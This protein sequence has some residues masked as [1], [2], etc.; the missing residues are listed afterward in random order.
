[1]TKYDVQVKAGPLLLLSLAALV[2]A[3]LFAPAASAAPV[4]TQLTL[5]GP[6]KAPGGT[7]TLTAK[8]AAN[9]QPLGGKTVALFAGQ[10]SP[11]VSGAT[12]AAG[13]IA[14]EVT[15]AASTQFQ[16]SYDPAPADAATYAPAKSKVLTVAPASGTRLSIQSYLRAGHRAVG[17]P[18][19]R[20]KV[21]A[22]IARFAATLTV[23]VFKGA[24][25]VHHRSLGVK[26]AGTG[27]VITFYFKPGGRGVYR[28]RVTDAGGSTTK[29]LY[30][31]SPH[32]TIGSGGNAVRA[33]QSRMRQLGYLVPVNGRFDST[34]G[35]AVLAFRKANGYAR[36]MS[37]SSA[38]FRKLALGG[39][40]FHVR[41][42]SAG[43]HVEFDWS[44]QVLVLARGAKAEKILPASSGKPSTPTVFGKFHFYSKTPGYNAHGMYYSNY[45]VGGYA[46]HGYDPVPT[47]AASH[48]CI[49][50]P[51]P[52]AK[53]VYRWV[54]LGDTIYVYR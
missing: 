3:L 44:R 12:D 14:F 38:V 48:G 10:A 5:T 42:P 21:R 24:R 45:F 13:Q 47:Y 6:S 8:L 32:A 39:G 53:A 29:R 20:V 26:H 9:G 4:A 23:D 51:I 43:K 34:T 2:A 52:S 36:T 30:V 7:T 15:V 41:Y 18:H 40:G 37:A 11:V 16:A 46:I 19:T 31:V 50:I 49:R 35:R 22:S 1:V 25:R 33:L 17:V 27:G 28:I 54:R